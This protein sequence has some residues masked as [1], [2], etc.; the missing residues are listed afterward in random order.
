[1]HT[2]GRPSPS[3]CSLTY[4]SLCAACSSSVN[5]CTAAHREPSGAHAALDKGVLESVGDP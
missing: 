2:G 5:V 3:A 4:R 1:M